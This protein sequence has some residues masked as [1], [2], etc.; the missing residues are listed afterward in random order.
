[1][2]GVAAMIAMPAMSFTSFMSLMSALVVIT[3]LVVMPAV[4]MVVVCIFLSNWHCLMMIVIMHGFG[5]CSFLL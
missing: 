4:M 5:H 3:G 1:M 2:P